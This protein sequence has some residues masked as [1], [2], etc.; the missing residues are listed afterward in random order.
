[1]LVNGSRKSFIFALAFVSGAAFWAYQLLWTLRLALVFGHTA[2]ATTTEFAAFAGALAI[3]TWIWGHVADRHPQSLLRIFAIWEAAAGLYAIA[4]LWIVRGIE[5]AYASIYSSTADHAILFAAVHFFLI[6]V[7]IL[8]PTILMA[9]SLPLLGNLLAS[10]R[11]RIVA[12]AGAVYGWIMLGAAAGTA[13]TIYGLLPAVGLK[14]SVLL[15]AGTSVLV[16]IAAF[17][18]EKLSIE[19][20]AEPNRVAPLRGA[21]N[22]SRDSATTLLI[23]AGFAL[24]GLAATALADGWARLLGMAM[25]SSIYVHGSLIVAVLAA[26][27]MGS[28]FYCRKERTT[29]EHRLRFAALEC[30]VAFTGALSMV[31]LTRIPLLFLRFSPL[32]RKA[33]GWKSIYENANFVFAWPYFRG[34]MDERLLKGQDDHRRARPQLAKDGGLRQLCPELGRHRE[35]AQGQCCTRTVAGIAGAQS[36]AVGAGD[37]SKAEISRVHDPAS[38]GARWAGPAHAANRRSVWIT[39]PSGGQVPAALRARQRGPLPGVQPSLITGACSSSDWTVP[40]V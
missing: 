13:A 14:V 11:R 18:V 38:R 29:E 16:G 15:T 3:G 35:R 34:A 28:V 6:A 7:A 8:P 33:F 36:R 24:S 30:G 5:W 39:G 22:A 25:G 20:T 23:L 10:T 12:S 9:G 17:T 40:S 32:F 1:M 4:N 31:T 27:G 37:F 26:L 2:I 21:A 19:R